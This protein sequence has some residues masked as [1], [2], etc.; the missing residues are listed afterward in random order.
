MAWLSFMIPRELLPVTPRRARVDIKVTGPVGRIEILGIK[1]GTVTSLQ[2][3]M[4]PVGSVSIE[5]N[6][7]EAITVDQEGRLALGISAGDPNRPEL[8]H[9]LSP[10]KPTDDQ[11]RAPIQI[12]QNAKV[13]YWRI[14]SLGL[15]LWATT[16]EPIAR[17]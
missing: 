4:D 8:T 5:L 6:D 11:T 14:E 10:A 7:P 2:T 9:N 12:D 13:N 17:D 15:T 1:Q 16:T 3:F